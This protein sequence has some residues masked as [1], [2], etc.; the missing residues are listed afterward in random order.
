MLRQYIL[1]EQGVA[2][3]LYAAENSGQI[4]ALLQQV[5]TA[6]EDPPF[7]WDLLIELHP[8]VVKLSA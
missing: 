3:R 2:F 5:P 1:G 4:P 8:A 6:A 7:N